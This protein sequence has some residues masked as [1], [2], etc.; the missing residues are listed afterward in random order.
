MIIFACFVPHTPLLIPEI[1]KEHLDKLE[2]TIK[3]YQQLEQEL[4]AA[5]PEV[6]IIISPHGEAR[7]GSFTIEQSPKLKADFKK[8]GDLVTKLEF[9]NDI[10]LGYQIKESCE[11]SLSIMLVSS[12]QLHYASAV[13]LYYLTHNLGNIKVVNIVYSDLSREDHIKFGEIIKEEAEKS[14]KR[15]AIIASGDLSHKLHQDSPAG[16][17]PQAQEFDQS[18]IKLVNDKKIKQI[19]NL[20]KELIAEAGECG[21]RSLLILL[22]VIKDLN[23]EPE[24]LSYQAPFGIGYL[25]E[26]FK[27]K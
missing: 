22:G 13:P 10:G 17:S 2:Q 8:F 18:I 16:Y 3:A 21:Y 24:Q 23:Y 25:V 19:I 26:N 7:E 5:K 12:N 4:Y 20:D 1:G 14:G 6:I 9:S 11:T 15:T 27:L